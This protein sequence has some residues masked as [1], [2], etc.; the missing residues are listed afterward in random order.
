MK[1][2]VNDFQNP[3]KVGLSGDAAAVDK[4]TKLYT[5]VREETDA[6]AHL[7]AIGL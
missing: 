7:V 3:D 4:L 6:P 2:A 5:P 1:S